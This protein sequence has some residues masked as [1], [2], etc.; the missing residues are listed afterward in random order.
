MRKLLV[1]AL[2]TIPLVVAAQSPPFR[3]IEEPPVLVLPAGQ[4]MQ[5]TTPP[6]SGLS[7]TQIATLK[8]LVDQAIAAGLIVIPAGKTQADVEQLLV[9]ADELYLSSFPTTPAP[10]TPT[11]PPPTPTPTPT[12]PPTT[13]C[14]PPTTGTINVC[15][16]MPGATLQSPVAISVSVMDPNGILRMA[17][18]SDPGILVSKQ[19]SADNVAPCPT[20]GIYNDL[21]TLS[22]GNH[23][24]VFQYWDAT[25][26]VIK[27]NPIP[28]TVQ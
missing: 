16:P 27:S 9:V 23:E 17:A 28:I 21:A 19:P 18:Y 15:S 4:A 1:V 24:I 2:L 14:A 7:P 20:S 8:S 6:A 26:K 13:S 22:P 25:G 5:T 11:P 3:I 10:P 12:P